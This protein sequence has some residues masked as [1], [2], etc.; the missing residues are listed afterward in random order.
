MLKRR[1]RPVESSDDPRRVKKDALKKGAPAGKTRE[2]SLQERRFFLLLLV[3]ISL[4]FLYQ[5]GPFLEPVF[6]ACVVGILFQGLHRRSLGL[7][8]GRPNIAALAT[9]LV[10]VTL[11][12][13]P[14]L[15][16][17]GAF[18]RE[19]AALYAR[20]QAGNDDIGA[21]I[22]G[23]RRA[24]PAVLGVLES[25]GMSTESIK[26]GILD[27]AVA[28]TRYIAQN[29]VQIGQGTLRFF[30]S[31]ALML[32]L[33]FFT[34]RDG[35]RLAALLGRALPLGGRRERLLFSRFAEVTRATVRGN[36]VVA[37][38]QGALG[39]AIF[40][41]LG[42]PWYLFWGVGMMFL[43]L[44]PV[45]G[46]GL[47][48]GPVAVYLFATGAWGEGLILTLFGMGV[49][50]LVD[51]I[52]RPILVGRDTKLPDYLVLLSTIGGIS[53]FGMSGF[54]LGPIVASL[55][56][57]AWELFMQEFQSQQESAEKDRQA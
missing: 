31:L 24:F 45:V 6:W 34:L 11:A 57:A 47:I 12:I 38:V 22:D 42:I 46:A 50:G 10:C 27:A 56:V 28:G 15:L 44:I 32:Y 4:L 40:W 9:L 3:A 1:K 16:F 25:L 48:W 17:L 39:T 21:Y 53:L 23:V 7:F 26:G 35:R 54:V 43:S 18:F 49:I 13:V 29:T 37:V 8:G 20:L 30:A 14:T 36:L 51:N 55:F 33:S 52:L 5:L 19:G 2:H 41:F